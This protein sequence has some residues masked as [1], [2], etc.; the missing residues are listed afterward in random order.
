MADEEEGRAQPARVRGE[1][2]SSVQTPDLPDRMANVSEQADEIAGAVVLAKAVR[3]AAAALAISAAL[4]EILGVT[5][6]ELERPGA[7]ERAPE[8]KV[9]ARL[10][11]R[12][13]RALVGS[14]GGDEAAGRAWFHAPNGHLDGVPAEL[15][16]TRE[17]LERVVAYV[18]MIADA[19]GHVE[20]LLG[21]VR[22]EAP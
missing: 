15:V 21:V 16:R 1:A 2:R 11:V 9:R 20:C 10:F 5:P 3:R 6:E 7:L 13:Y 12:L 4:G 17:G 22:R 14:L 18:E 8:W 19:G